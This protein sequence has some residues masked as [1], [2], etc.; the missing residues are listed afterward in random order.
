M[1]ATSF[2]LVRRSAGHLVPKTRERPRHRQHL[3][4]SLGDKEDSELQDN[5]NPIWI[6]GRLTR[7]ITASDQEGTGTPAPPHS[8]YMD[9]S[10]GAGRATMG[11]N[12]NLSTPDAGDVP[13]TGI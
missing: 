11:N 1:C 10:N 12:V 9:A 4:R 5:E 6:P 3:R 7:S 13:L 2:L 8:S